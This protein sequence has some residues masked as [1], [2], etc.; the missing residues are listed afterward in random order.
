MDRGVSITR[1]NPVMS[2]LPG[3]IRLNVCAIV[4]EEENAGVL[5]VFKRLREL[6]VRTFWEQGRV[7]HC[8][9]FM[10]EYPEAVKDELPDVVRE[11]VAGDHD[12]AVACTGM[13]APGSGWLFLDLDRSVIQSVANK[14][15][16]ALQPSRAKQPRRPSWLQAGTRQDEMF[17]KYGSP[18]VRSEFNP[19]L[20]LACVELPELLGVVFRD[21]EFKALCSSVGTVQ[22]RGIGVAEADDMGQFTRANLISIWR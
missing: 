11:S 20:S 8:T 21:E 16:D 18:N 5:K 13:S 15:A 1:Y 17:K 10:T 22:L 6:G 9:L 14:L 3:Q 7:I 19:H 4:P 2:Q 12:F